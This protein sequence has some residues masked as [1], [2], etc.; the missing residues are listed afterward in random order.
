M[1][2]FYHEPYKCQ[3]CLPQIITSTVSATAD[4]AVTSAAWVNATTNDNATTTVLKTTS[5]TTTA[6]ATTD[7]DFALNTSVSYKSYWVVTGKYDDVYGSF[8]LRAMRPVRRHQ[9]G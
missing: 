5:T 4:S 9:R 2:S 3:R 1:L 8:S 7:N 6:T